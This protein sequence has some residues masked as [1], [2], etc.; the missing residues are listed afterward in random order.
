MPDRGRLSR[1]CWSTKGTWNPPYLHYQEADPAMQD[2][3]ATPSMAPH[4]GD[5]VH[6]VPTRTSNFHFARMR[7][8]EQ[9]ARSLSVQTSVRGFLGAGSLDEFNQMKAVRDSYDLL[10]AAHRQAGLR[11]ERAERRAAARADFRARPTAYTRS[12]VRDTVRS[13]RRLVGV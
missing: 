10:A 9:T 1:R 11:R 6:T 13:I 5:F 4:P 2:L 12:M 7:C 8:A 3:T